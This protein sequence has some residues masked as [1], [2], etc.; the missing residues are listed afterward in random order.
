MKLKRYQS[1]EKKGDRQNFWKG[2]P[3]TSWETIDKFNDTECI[4]DYWEKTNG[5]QL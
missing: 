3:D 1:T 2:Y 4:N 5:E